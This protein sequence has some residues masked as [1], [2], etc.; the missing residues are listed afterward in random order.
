MTRD[1]LTAAD[2]LGIH[3]ALIKKYGGADGVRDMGA[4]EAAVFRL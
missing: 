4:V 2:V 3:A 1:Y